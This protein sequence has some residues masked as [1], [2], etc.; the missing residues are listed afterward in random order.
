MISPIAGVLEG[1]N[2]PPFWITFFATSIW[3]RW[4]TRSIFFFRQ[5]FADDKRDSQRG[6]DNVRLR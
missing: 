4:P 3:K 2:T 5:R 6:T 1:I